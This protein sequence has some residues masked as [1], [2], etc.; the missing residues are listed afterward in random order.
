MRSNTGR[1]KNLLS[2]LGYALE[3]RGVS[4]SEYF[5]GNE[6]DERAQDE[7]LCLLKSATGNWF[8]IYIERGNVSQK[9]V[10]SSFRDAMQCFYW[11]LT[12]KDTPWDFREDWEKEVGQLI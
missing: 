11:K 3:R 7:K 1:E 12:R 8:I 6:G 10:H 5:I 9:V 4:T 2:L